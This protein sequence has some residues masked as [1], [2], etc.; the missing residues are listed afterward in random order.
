[1]K[2]KKKNFISFIIIKIFLVLF[3][4]YFYNYQ[5]FEFENK[6]QLLAVDVGNNSEIFGG[7]IL[8]LDL[9]IK[10]GTGK[11]YFDSNTIKELDT[12]LSIK[13]SNK[14][15]CSIFVLDCENYDFFYTFDERFLYLKGPSGGSSIAIL[16]AATI[17][18]KIL[19]LDVIMTGSVGL[20]GIVGNV[21]G[22]NEKILISKERGIKKILIP[23]YSNNI[24]EFPEMEI[25]R[26]L[27]LVE[28][29][30]IF[31][32]SNFVE[33]TIKQNLSNY[34][35]SMFKISND[36]CKKANILFLSSNKSSETYN[37][38]KDFLNLSKI[39]IKNKN[40]YSASSYCFRANINLLNE[41]YKDKNISKKNVSDEFIDIEKKVLIFENRINSN[42][43]FEKKILTK[44]DFYIYLI[45]KSRINEA[46]KFIKIFKEEE[47]KNIS[48]NNNSNNND[49]GLLA[50]IK[51]R[52]DTLFYW[53]SIIKNEGESFSFSKKNI[54]D[55]C[56]K[57]KKEI[58]NGKNL[59]QFYEIDFF[60]E[61]IL[62]Y[63]KNKDVYLCIYNGIE[64]N[65]K[66]NSIHS[67][68]QTSSNE[69]IKQFI[70]ELNNIT[71]KRIS[72]SNDFS[73]IPYL[74][75]EYSNSLLKNND[76]QGSLYYSNYALSFSEI[77]IYFNEEKKFESFLNRAHNNLLENEYLLYLFLI[78]LIFLN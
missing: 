51:S 52:L 38:S 49:Y 57:I 9:K 64:L 42:D 11:I 35:K 23:K 76:L 16:T 66:I 20:G 19:N 25:I 71:I 68:I 33:K 28:A 8:N 53:E 31:T 10:K 14:I 40:F 74:Y 41:Y 58:I 5:T 55:S 60:N 34:E 39:D 36:I 54:Q 56:S 50:S 63:K 7:D 78:L 1:M 26:V 73:I 48:E 59:L 3:I 77:N 47:L 4:L 61:E 72:N 27:D 46:K 30:N 75:L 37:L 13:N 62:E 12:Q 24:S 44:N 29:Y 69:T 32:N 21:G 45:L 18:K 70:G 67:S 2:K 22:V 17:N 15:A 43:Y 65:S 6:I